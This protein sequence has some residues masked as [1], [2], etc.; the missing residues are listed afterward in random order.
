MIAQPL[1]PGALVY[2]NLQRCWK[3][4]APMSEKLILK[5]LV[6]TALI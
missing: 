4:Y 3:D 6:P 1:L 2:I 5:H